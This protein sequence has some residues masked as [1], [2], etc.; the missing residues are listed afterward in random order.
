[1]RRLAKERNFGEIFGLRYDP[2]A[3]LR[4][5]K[6]FAKPGFSAA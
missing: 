6:T 5:R 2:L 1:M 3:K 4:H